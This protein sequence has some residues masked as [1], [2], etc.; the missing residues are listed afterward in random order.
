MHY[1]NYEIFAAQKNTG[2]SERLAKKE[3]V[4]IKRFYEFTVRMEM[5]NFAVHTNFGCTM[6]LCLNID[7][8]INRPERGRESNKK[9]RGK[10]ENRLYNYRVIKWNIQWICMPYPKLGTMCTASSPTGLVNLFISIDSDDAPFLSFLFFA[11]FNPLDKRTQQRVLWDRSSV[12]LMHFIPHQT[13]HYKT[14]ICTGHM[15]NTFSLA[16]KLSNENQ[17]DVGS[18]YTNSNGICFLCVCEISLL[19]L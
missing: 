12:A 7:F 3:W 15:S 19:K 14:C 8:Y 11:A 9:R 18:V 13:T 6:D 16:C 17:L 2:Q 1:R 4:A 5:G 10:N